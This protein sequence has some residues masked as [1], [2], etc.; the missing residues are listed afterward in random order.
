[1]IYNSQNQLF[2]IAIVTFKAMLLFNF[3]DLQKY[4]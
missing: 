2:F 1:M 4:C 3:F